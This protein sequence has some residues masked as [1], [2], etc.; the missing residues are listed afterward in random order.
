[1]LS[2]SIGISRLMRPDETW[3]E[4]Q[5]MYWALIK[6]ILNCSYLVSERNRSAV[7]PVVS[8]ID[9]KLERCVQRAHVLKRS[10][11]SL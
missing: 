6:L 2:T 8:G 9:G 10:H 11:N 3:E 4:I 7:H 1:M 5:M